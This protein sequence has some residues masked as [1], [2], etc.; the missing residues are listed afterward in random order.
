ML[1]AA[2]SSLS[3]SAREAP[4][5]CGEMELSGHQGLG[6]LKGLLGF[7]V[8]PD[9][10]LGTFPSC[11]RDLGF[12]HS[13]RGQPRRASF[14][15]WLTGRP[16]SFLQDFELLPSGDSYPKPSF[17]LSSTKG[18]VSLPLPAPN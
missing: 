1:V 16:V 17:N 8:Q 6:Q 2:V 9:A 7:H 12:N 11:P 5:C 3:A 10:R 13:P 14:S 18:Q 15:W 4:F